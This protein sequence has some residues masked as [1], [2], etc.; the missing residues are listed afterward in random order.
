MHVPS[1]K[2]TNEKQNLVRHI[3]KL[4]SHKESSTMNKIDLEDS[5]KMI[6]NKYQ[7][8]NRPLNSMLFHH[9][10]RDVQNN[11]FL[12]N[13]DGIISD[14]HFTRD[15]FIFSVNLHQ[16]GLCNANDHRSLFNSY[17]Q[18]LQICQGVCFN[19]SGG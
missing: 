6:E 17:G 4:C 16:N 19:F 15:T 8:F 14:L 13:V 18:T 9:P 10:H 3:K 7:D 12:N 5:T 11:D 1:H 2:L